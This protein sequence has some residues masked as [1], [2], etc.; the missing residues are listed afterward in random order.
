MIIPLPGSTPS[1]H[2]GMLLDRYLVDL[3]GLEQKKTPSDA[4][5]R[6][7]LHVKPPAAYKLAFDRWNKAV[8]PRS[9][10]V[11]VTREGTVAGRFVTGLGAEGVFDINIRLHHTYG[12]PFVPGTGLKGALRA[13]ME[14][15]LDHT[16][17]AAF[18]FGT[19]ESA[20]FARVFDAWWVP[21][22]APSCG[23]ALDVISMHHPEYYG[24]SGRKAPTDFEQPTPVHF[25]TAQGKFLFV[26]EA[27]TQEWGAYLENLLPDAL[28]SSGVGAKK[29]SGYGRFSFLKESR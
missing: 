28:A 8:S 13:Y 25:L 19:T 10:A 1:A 6:Q 2:S 20:G 23:L 15:S 27:P 24:G 17:A 9:P 26:L 22:S 21:G 3:Q 5:W 7:L 18:L 12:V 14:H 29:T 11:R 16:E 4:E